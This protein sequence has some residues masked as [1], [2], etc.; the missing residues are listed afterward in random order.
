[1]TVIMMMIY[2]CCG[3]NC[4]IGD[5]SRRIFLLLGKGKRGWEGKQLS[6]HA[7]CVVV[8]LAVGVVVGVVLV[9]AGSSR[10][11]WIAKTEHRK[12]KST[13]QTKSKIEPAPAPVLVF[14]SLLALVLVWFLFFSRPP[15]G[16]WRDKTVQDKRQE[17]HNSNSNLLVYMP[18]PL[19]RLTRQAAQT[20]RYTILEF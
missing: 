14:V 15:W 13:K 10:C 6:R 16:R 19:Y 4:G 17:K 3:G 2:S 18:S 1:M 5:W 11:K 20:W 8:V 12:S 7:P 9:V